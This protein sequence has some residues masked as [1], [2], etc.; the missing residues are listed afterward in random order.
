MLELEKVR[1]N[2][3]REL[4]LQKMVILERVQ[5]ELTKIREEDDGDANSVNNL[6]AEI[7]ES[8]QETEFWCDEQGSMYR[9]SQTGSFQQIP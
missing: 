5:V 4:H 2:F 7:L 6:L 9:N 1:M 8:F 3:Q